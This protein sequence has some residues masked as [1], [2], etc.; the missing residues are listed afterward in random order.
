MA[1]GRPTIARSQTLEPPAPMAMSASAI[2]DAISAVSTHRCSAGRPAASRLSAGRLAAPRRRAPRRAAPRPARRPARGTTRSVT[3]PT[4]VRPSA[5]SG[6]AD[7]P[8]LGAAAQRPL[9][10]RA[11]LRPHQRVG[12]TGQHLGVGG[13]SGRDSAS[14][15]AAVAGIEQ[16]I[17]VVPAVGQV[18]D[19]HDLPPGSRCN[20]A[21]SPTPAAVVVDHDDV[22]LEAVGEVAGVGDRPA[23]SWASAIASSVCAGQPKRRSTGAA[24]RDSTKAHSAPRSISARASVRQRITWPPPTSGPASAKKRMRGSLWR[25]HVMALSAIHAT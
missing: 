20:A 25:A 19:D 12:W 14:R 9:P 23:R 15:P 3:P 4:S 5:T 2:S 18:V 13:R 1:D 6:R 8:V 22:G 11:E 10:R 17:A 24:A 16:Q 21:S 7:R